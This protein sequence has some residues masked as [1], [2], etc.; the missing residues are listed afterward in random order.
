MAKAPVAGKVKTR[1]VPPLT[2]EEAAE[3]YHCLLADLFDS[4]RPSASAD[5]FV[6]YTPPE[7]TGFRADLAAK[8]IACFSQRGSDL[9]ERMDSVFQDLLG[10]GYGSVVVIGSDLPVLPAEFLKQ[11]YVALETV[12]TDLVL[13]PNRDGGYYLV[14]MRRPLPEIF[15]N[16]PWGSDKVLSATLE[17]IYGL[18][19]R[20][21]L[22]PAW[23]D[24]DTPDDL[25]RLQAMAYDLDPVRQPRT[26]H[27]LGQRNKDH[28]TF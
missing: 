10:D 2:F 24:I 20:A 19:L 26:L 12:E 7:A 18:G 16:M 11:A 5:L 27:W 15:A 6:A 17:R 9:G 3:L 8:G 22:L 28:R 1:L 23:F 4:L 13:G 25:D 14:G 21:F